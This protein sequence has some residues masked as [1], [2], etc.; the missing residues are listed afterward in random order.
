MSA[1]C[2]SCGAANAEGFRF[3]GQCGA[4][5]AL[6]A[7]AGCGGA[8]PPGQRFCGH[9]GTPLDEPAAAGL[10]STLA[11]QERKLATVLFADVVGFTSLAERTDAEVVARTVD[12]AFHRLADVVAEHGGVVDKYM[13]DSVMAV[14][15]VPTS[16]DDDA[17]RAVAAGLAMRE[18]GG[19]LSFSIGINSGEVM[20][21]G[22]GPE[23]RPTVIGDVVNV[24]ARLEKAAGAGEVL[25][26]KLTAELARGRILFH[27]RRAVVLKGK[28]EPVEVHEAIALRAEQD[29][30]DG[31]VGTSRL[32]GRDDDLAF[33]LS[34]WRRTVTDSRA[35]VVL[36]TGDAGCGKTRL[37][38]EVVT[39]V[40]ACEEATVVRTA[41]P[42]YGGLG[43]PRVAAEVVRQLGPTGDHQ[44]DTRIRSIAG[45][46]H[47]TLI[48]IDP[49][50]LRQEQVWALRCLF[51]AKAAE[52]PVLVVIDDM[53]RAG[54]ATLDLLADLLNR[55]A[56]VP[57]LLLLA[58]RGEP[59]DWLTR[60][61]AA[62]SLRLS[63]LT[64][65]D[66]AEL[67]AALLSDGELA[68][69][70]S[71]FLVDRS[72]G[73]PLY[74]RELVTVMQERDGLVRRDDGRYHLAANVP[75]PAT[76]QAV[77]AARLDALGPSQKQAIQHV[78]VLGVATTAEQ[79]AAFGL[80]EAKRVLD[81]LVAA[82][83]LRIN[84]TDCYDVIDPLLRE[85]AYES[86]PRRLRGKRHRAAA[87]TATTSD[88]RA[89][90]LGRAAFYL[91][92]DAALVAE[93]AGALR[94]AADDLRR[95]SRTIDAVRLLRRAV[96]LEPDDVPTVLVYAKSLAEVGRHDE[97]ER[98]LAEALPVELH[99]PAHAAERD[100]IVLAG[101][102][103]TDPELA[104]EGLRDV[105]ATWHGL[106]RLIDEG[107]AHANA[108]AALFNLSRMDESQAEL[109][110][111]LAA[112]G[113][114]GDRSG[115]TA[116]Y[117]FL[118][119]IRPTDPRVPEWLH[120]S[121]EWAEA[122]G[123]QHRQ[124]GTMLSLSW[125]DYFRLRLG[126]PEEAAPA[127]EWCR[128]TAELAE[129]LHTNDLASHGRALLSS[130]YR[131]A[132][133]V[134][135]AAAVLDVDPGLVGPGTTM[136]LAAARGGVA[137]A[138]PDAATVSVPLIEPSSEPTAKAAA[139]MLAESFALAGRVDDAMAQ[140]RITDPSRQLGA[141]GEILLIVEGL[142]L[143]LAGRGEEAERSLQR[144]RRGG[145]RVDSRSTVLA[146]EALLAEV[147]GDVAGL[148][149]DPP[150]GLA[151]AFVLRARARAGDEGAG[152]RLRSV[153]VELAAPGLLEGLLRHRQP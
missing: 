25:V 149:A 123:D 15:G 17:E 132:G 60:F 63:P 129:D 140:Y 43:G 38:D 62:T 55:I 24:A 59:G 50:A 151:G 116:V 23:G 57:V 68:V 99:D 115:E 91:P 20:V 30:G 27:E 113:A 58:G 28:S 54:T 48:G 51:E 130:L 53:H 133:R 33:V 75:L 2:A 85:V 69:D 12:A 64:R 84:E 9:C 35:T 80:T 109:E 1:T 26:G 71:S 101:K 76:L 152:A 34:Q 111:A 77:L 3:C 127:I 5:L 126:T 72:G 10:P 86:L 16:H 37:V 135:A 96:E 110:Q 82:G 14:F 104:Y 49:S 117:S 122:T 74:L 150:A 125:H 70:A 118:P 98:V 65:T 87:E 4:P 46:L 22:L 52:G 13:G 31:T 138:G 114:A 128:R 94:V 120:G 36:V 79:V 148:P 7:C 18:L 103:F 44:V 19:D 139:A 147:S 136:L 56:G 105:A 112:F 119:L 81:S 143:V 144:V 29:G 97:A 95:A 137:L 131:L 142:M 90:H 41:Y 39:A 108:G 11:T 73:N 145:E 102:M 32:V 107:W 61:P 134:D 21:T 6:V 153:A 40:A 67:A 146:A 141:T 88:E 8:N 78:A 106:G 121:L 83:F 124:L 47:P 92:D 45:E 42:G 93:A 66:T 100:H 89:R